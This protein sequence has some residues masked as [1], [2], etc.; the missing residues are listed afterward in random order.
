[1]LAPI[2]RPDPEHPELTLV[3]DFRQPAQK[4]WAAL[5]TP[6]RFSA[7]MDADWL[8]DATPQPGSD[9]SFRMRQPDLVARG[10]V[11]RLAAGTLL[12]HTWFEDAPWAA[13]VRW[14]LA[15][16]AAGGSRLTLTHI[17]GEPD[18]AA[19]AG[20]G[21]ADLLKS[22]ANSLGEAPDPDLA[23]GWPAALARMKTLLPYEAV[24]DAAAETVG[25]A[26][27]TLTYVRKIARP[28][29]AAWS[30]VSTAEGVGR[31]MGS[32]AEIGAGVGAPFTLRVKDTGHVVNGEITAW[33][34]ERRI[35]FTW[36][37][38][39]AGEDSN[40]DIRLE[41]DGPDATRLTLVL[42]LSQRT[43]IVGFACG[44]H[45]RLDQVERAID[46]VTAER[47]A[48]RLQALRKIYEMTL[49]FGVPERES[50]G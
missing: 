28:L 40:I 8:G 15:P 37:E 39:D 23:G 5:T 47:R 45:G 35:A 14:E 18:D 3:R 24:R 13:T 10:R 36:P 6:E 25:A 22:L 48:D 50:A 26:G 12:E 7:W 27:A 2:Y 49:P 11:L 20:A 38:A 4:V 43:N 44:W 42:H 46:G 34:P 30:T 9:F 29:A 31:W 33:E 21:W 1:M 17:F 16:T 32:D 19:R 41:A